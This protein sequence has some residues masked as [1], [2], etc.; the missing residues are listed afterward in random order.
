[1]ARASRLVLISASLS[2]IFFPPATSAQVNAA[3]VGG[4]VTDDTGAALPG[5][6]IAITN[7][8]TGITQTQVTGGEGNYRAVAL[9]PGPYEITTDIQGFAPQRREL[10]LT[11]GAD[12]TVNFKL[13][14]AGVSETLTVVSESPLVEVTRAAPSS[15]I[16]ADQLKALPVISRNFLVLAQ[17]LPGVSPATG[18]FA[19]SRFGGGADPRNGYT[20]I[21]DGGDIDDA[22]WGSPTIN[23]TQDAVQ[24]FK[25]YRNQ[26]DAQYGQAM[27]AVVTVVT[28]SGTNDLNGSAFYFGRD[29]ALNATDPFA[30]TKPPFRQTPRAYRS[31][32]RPDS[33]AGA[34]ASGR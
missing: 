15:V 22:I 7:R 25:V 24:E 18:R 5:V 12:A 28:K 21:I 3:N 10:T 11:V 16:E 29:D 1:M 34:A 14:V 23:L 9:Q 13:A 4:A 33:S 2:F 8:A 26:F 17:T 32:D 30:T 20:T 27:S 19:T 6:T 31:R